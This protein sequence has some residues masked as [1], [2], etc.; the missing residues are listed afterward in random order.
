MKNFKIIIFALLALIFILLF[1]FG[2]D[3]SDKTS[4]KNMSDKVP[5][6]GQNLWVYNIQQHQW[7]NY[8]KHDYEIDKNNEII[9]RIKQDS[10]NPDVTAYDL[11]TENEDVTS[12]NLFISEGSIEFIVGNKLYTYHPRTFEYFEIV[13]NG[14]NFVMRRLE[15]NAI[16]KLFPDYK[17]IKLSDFNN[18]KLDINISKDKQNYIII[19]DIGE[20]FYRY[21]IT[22]DDINKIEINQFSNQF[23]FNEPLKIKLQRFEGCTKSYPCYEINF[24]NE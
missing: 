8:L 3:V 9:L 24:M 7:H 11:V 22:T 14:F 19:N 20:S 15:T 23:S 10:Q 2:V 21:Y 1:I 4:S 16:T 6:I 13:F 18:R 12:K 5:R 17:I